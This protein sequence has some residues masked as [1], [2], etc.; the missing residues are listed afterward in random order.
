MSSMCMAAM[1]ALAGI[2]L[3]MDAARA[4]TA[5][6]RFDGTPVSAERIDREATRMMAEAKVQG[7]AMAVIGDG[8]D[9]KERRL[10]EPAVLRDGDAF[11]I[12]GQ[13]LIY[14]SSRLDDLTQTGAEG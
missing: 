13:L 14:S 12:G 8:K 2:V 6:R 11:R 10:N 3:A 4:D 7:L 9:L 5:I 1:A